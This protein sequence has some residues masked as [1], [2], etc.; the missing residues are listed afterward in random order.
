MA[1]YAA[2][3][4]SSGACGVDYERQNPSVLEAYDAFVGYK[5]VYEAACR[6]SPVNSREYCYTAA[7]TDQTEP[8]SSYIYYLPVGLALPAGT[9]PTCSQCLSQTMAGYSQYAGNGS[10]PLSTVYRDAMSQISLACGPNFVHA[11]IP[12]VQGAASA[13]ARSS[14]GF[15]MASLVVAVLVVS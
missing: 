14:W 9:D 12:V 15:L 3:I 2:Q 8:T 10:Q 6:K 11:T 1:S 13:I 7:V 4:R 5:A